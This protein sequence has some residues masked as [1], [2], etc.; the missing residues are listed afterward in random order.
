MAKQFKGTINLGTPALSRGKQRFQRCEKMILSLF[1]VLS[2][3]R[4]RR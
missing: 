2:A 1:F 4:D 3:G